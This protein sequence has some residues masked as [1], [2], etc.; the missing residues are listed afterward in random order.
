MTEPGETVAQGMFMPWREFLT[1]FNR[2]DTV[3]YYRG[4]SLGADV[5]NNAAAQAYRDRIWAYVIDGRR[6]SFVQKRV[7]PQCFEYRAI[8][9]KNMGVQHGR[10]KPAR[11]LA[12]GGN[13]V[14]LRDHFAGRSS[15]AAG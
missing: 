4:E 5:E 6:G 7:G 9:Y 15:A 12:A 10:E 14:R 11:D 8:P 13:I 1:R 3:V 2:G